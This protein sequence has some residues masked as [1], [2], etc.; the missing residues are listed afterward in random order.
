MRP[1]SRAL[2]A[3]AVL[4]DLDGVLADSQSAIESAWRDWARLHG[5]VTRDILPHIA[6]T[7]SED[8]VRKLAPSL[9]PIA[10]SEWLEEREVEHP[11]T[12]CP[13][14]AE[15]VRAL[16]YTPWAV[17][18]SG[19]RTTAIARLH[20]IGIPVPAVLVTAFE[21]QRGKPDPEGYLSASRRLGVRPDRCVAI[22]DSAAGVAAASS[23]GARVIG[24]RGSAL[25]GASVDLLVGSLRELDML[26][27]EA[28]VTLTLARGNHGAASEAG[29]VTRLAAKRR[30]R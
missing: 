18:T 10:E 25:A 29:R 9:D 11:V 6:G 17:V 1:R 19:R 12:A 27:S 26:E 16:C 21:I 14:A 7:R 13:G 28:G 24:I 20:A 22:E 2:Q 15:F 8:V 5:L 30:P 4:L 23:A 3:Q